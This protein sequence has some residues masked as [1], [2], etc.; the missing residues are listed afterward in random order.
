MRLCSLTNMRYVFSGGVETNTVRQVINRPRLVK[1]WERSSTGCTKWYF[2]KFRPRRGSWRVRY[3][4][5]GPSLETSAIVIY[6]Y[7]RRGTIALE[8]TSIICHIILSYYLLH[9]VELYLT[10]F[11]SIAISSIYTDLIFAQITYYVVTLPL[12]RKI[13]YWPIII[14]TKTNYFFI[15]TCSAKNLYDTMFMICY[16]NITE[17]M[18]F[19]TY[20]NHFFLLELHNF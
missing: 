19:K 6:I 17:N 13:K 2:A 1:R 18:K 10:I 12:I 9:Y 5:N 20:I 15:Y 4:T 3:V 8:N 7:L 16:K 11:L 14:L